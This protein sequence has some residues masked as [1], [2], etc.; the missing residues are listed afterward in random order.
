M[1]S[2]TLPTSGTVYIDA[3]CAIYAV[4]KIA[5]YD[6]VLAPLWHAAASGQVSVVSSELI[7]LEALVRPMRD[8]NARLE[9][10]FRAF[11]FESAELQLSPVE[12]RII[13]HATRIRAAT[14]LKTP[15]AIHAA[16]ALASAAALFLTNDSGFRRIPELP[17]AVLSEVLAAA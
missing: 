16:T 6:A 11:L 9:A 4:E 12:F 10:A 3:N 7:V 5:P 8:N 2:L 15:D 14:G 1:G 17:V 13:E